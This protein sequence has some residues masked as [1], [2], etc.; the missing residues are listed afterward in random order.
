MSYLG[1]ISYLCHQQL[2]QEIQQRYWGRKSDSFMALLKQSIDVEND[3]ALVHKCSTENTCSLFSRTMQACGISSTLAMAI[4]QSCTKL[5]TWCC[6]WGVFPN[7]IQTNRI[8]FYSCTKCNLHANNVLRLQG[9]GHSIQTPKKSYEQKNKDC[10]LTKVNALLRTACL[11]LQRVIRRLPSN[12]PQQ[13][14]VLFVIG[15]II[16]YNLAPSFEEQNVKKTRFCMQ[17]WR[18]SLNIFDLCTH[19][20]VTW[21]QLNT[22][23]VLFW[24]LIWAPHALWKIIQHFMIHVRTCVLHPVHNMGLL[25]WTRSKFE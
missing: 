8:C 1:I 23:N 13:T 14:C 25:V 16:P 7:R 20:L 21:R 18:F 12:K 6:Y 2:H 22:R 17:Y 3:N 10:S 5:T 19:N 11:M 9:K 15:V 24:M 4:P